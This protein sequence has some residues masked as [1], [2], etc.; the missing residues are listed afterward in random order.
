PTA[1]DLVTFSAEPQG[2]AIR[3]TWE[4]AQELDN[5]GFNLYRGESAAGPWTRL[6]AELLPA[7]NPGATFGATYEWLDAD[8]TPDMTYFY[9]LEDVNVY[10]ASTFH[11]PVSTTAAMPSAVRITGF[12]ARGPAFGLP[13]AL[14]AL[15]LWGLARKR[16]R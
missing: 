12:G 2:N 6:N 14:A 8:V 5:L 4:T 13:L 1:V 11:G 3:V 9:R 16:R 7:Q 15:G 10:G